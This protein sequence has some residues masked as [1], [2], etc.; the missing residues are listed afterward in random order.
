MAVHK[1]SLQVAHEIPIGGKDIALQVYKGS[2]FHGTL[3]IS[4][5]GLDWKKTYARKSVS[6]DWTKFAEL[7]ANA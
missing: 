6:V 1:V 5:G 7:M 2:K 3:T 4:Q